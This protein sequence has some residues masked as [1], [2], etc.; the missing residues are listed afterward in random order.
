MDKA[1]NIGQLVAESS[2]VDGYVSTDEFMDLLHD[3][4]SNYEFIDNEPPFLPDTFFADYYP[5]Q[6][7]Q[8]MVHHRTGLRIDY[9]E[10]PIDEALQMRTAIGFMAMSR[11]RI[12]NA[13][14]SSAEKDI[15]NI[16]KLLNQE[17][18]NV[19]LLNSTHTKIYVHLSEFY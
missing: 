19:A 15:E 14:R 8:T 5:E 12:H 3:A 2:Y 1:R 13:G 16:L 4:D 6:S 10:I 9:A 7:A 11:F 18:Q 17:R